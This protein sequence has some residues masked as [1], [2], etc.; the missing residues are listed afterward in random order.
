MTTSKVSMIPTSG[1][2]RFGEFAF[3]RL[4]QTPQTYLSIP[5]KQILG[6]N[7]E[8]EEAKINKGKGHPL[9]NDGMDKAF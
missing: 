6:K 9:D 3:N 8:K 4:S 5:G 1:I 2:T 7:L